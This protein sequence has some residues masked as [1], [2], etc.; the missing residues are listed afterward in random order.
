MVFH[1]LIFRQ[2]H[3]NLKM[4]DSNIWNSVHG[5]KFGNERF[6]R[7]PVALSSTLIATMFYTHIN[8][9][10]NETIYARDD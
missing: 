2:S 7:V 8:I 1:C 6:Q 10:F 5:N 4:W 9:F 3:A